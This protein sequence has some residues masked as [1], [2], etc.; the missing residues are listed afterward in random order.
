MLEFDPFFP[1][2]ATT[3]DDTRAFITEGQLFRAHL[4]GNSALNGVYNARAGEPTRT[5]GHNADNND[6]PV[7]NTRIWADGAFP[8]N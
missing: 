4:N 5:C 6:C 8:A 1:A 3:D 2:E 7:L